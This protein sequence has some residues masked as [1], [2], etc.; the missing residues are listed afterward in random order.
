VPFADVESLGPTKSKAVLSKP[1]QQALVA[2]DGF[3][4]RSDARCRLRLGLP[5]GAR[6]RFRRLRE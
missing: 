2:F 6:G 1:V 3:E 5:K 4:Q